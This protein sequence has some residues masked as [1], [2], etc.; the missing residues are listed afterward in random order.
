MI[1]ELC[2]RDVP[3]TT[4]HHL[5]PRATHT[6]RLKRELG[7]E[8]N[9]KANLCVACHRQLH[10]L[11]ENKILGREFN[12]LELLRQNPEVITYLNWIR[13]RPGDFVPRKGK[14]KH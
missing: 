9:R 13:K 10:Y 8:R 12:T 5:V 4:E 7:D 3:R 2:E 6:K 14:R 1:C 11:F